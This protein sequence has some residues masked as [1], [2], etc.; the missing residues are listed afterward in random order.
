MPAGLD[1]TRSS[2]RLLRLRLA[3]LIALAI[4]TG[5]A[6]WFERS[7]PWFREWLA[8]RSR[9]D[10]SG[11]STAWWILGDLALGETLLLI[12]VAVLVV[13]GSRRRL[14]DAAIAALVA[15]IATNILKL[16]V[17][18][19][20]PAPHG[21][22]AWPSGHA[23]AAAAMAAALGGWRPAATT[24]G[25]LGA[26]GVAASRVMRGRHWPGDVL[27]GLLIGG[28]CG[29]LVQRLPLWL[30]AALERRRTR[31]VLAWGAVAWW[32]LALALRPSEGETA[33]LVGVVPAL[34]CGLWAV[35]QLGSDDAEASRWRWRAPLG[36]GA[37]LLIVLVMGHAGASHFALLDVDEPRF[38]AASRTMLAT[39][40]WVVPWFNGEER[41]DK[42]ILI[43]W[44]QALAMALVDPI[45]AAARLP[46]AVGVALAA[47]ATAGIGRLLGLALLPALLAGMIAATAP[48]AQALAHGATADGLLYGLVTAIA[49]VQIRRY[50]C[51]ADVASWLAL[52]V[53]IALAFLT[54]GPPAL[55]GPI[56]LAL[57]LCWA[58]AR[59]RPWPT[60][61]SIALAILLVA[62][63]GV[64]ALIQTDGGFFSR[65]VMHHV[66]ERSLRPFEGHGGFAPWWLLT[67]FVTIPLTMLPWSLLL[68]WAWNT[69]RGR[70]APLTVGAGQD[71]AP[72]TRR[73]LGIW[74][75]GVVG[76][77]TLVV[78]KLPHYVL[79]CYPALAL[80]IVLGRRQAAMPVMAFAARAVGVVLAIALPVA[81]GFA[82]FGR[83]IAAAIVTGTVLLTTLWCCGHWL[84]RGRTMPALTGMALG[85]GLAMAAW[86]GRALPMADP[87]LLARRF[88]NE[89]PAAVHDGETVSL[90]RLSAPSVTFYLD[91]VTP[92]AGDE[93][94][95]L[96]LLAEP[97]Q[98]VLMRDRQRDELAAAATT[99]AAADPVTARAASA[100]LA[101]PLWS[102]RGFLPTKG[103]MLEVV[104]CGHRAAAT[105]DK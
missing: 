100:A 53:G 86:F 10:G 38:A 24:L 94:A 63:W 105:S 4:A 92:A 74:V 77:F 76:T 15:G 39:H 51:G 79:P 49:F 61:G 17:M 99:L 21:S 33:L 42:P 1:D 40:D 29:F 2:R 65:G 46:S 25:W 30:P 55:V 71:L 96:R 80:A 26:F 31:L 36:Y 62:A 87:E 11:F 34:A 43:Y 66:V 81:V 89:L 44:L 72:A 37:L 35:Q 28:I 88:A 98:L 3:A 18:R 103:K 50:R 7:T 8:A 101:A 22:Y 45:E 68:P 27:G 73:L 58:G 6:I 91:R 56:A 48:L 67:Y 41:F 14:Q 95:T 85:V 104:L 59:P 90:Y 83:P 93:T 78:S 75:L 47:V 69:L 32:A 5:V 13:G 70:A 102:A 84:A 82:G 9:H 97:G 23:A 20:R 16:A 64:P 54:K 12:L 19:E 57:G 60:L 52:W